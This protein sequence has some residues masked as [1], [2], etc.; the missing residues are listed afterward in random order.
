[1]GAIFSIRWASAAGTSEGDLSVRFVNTVN[2]L[3]TSVNWLQDGRA[4]A[5]TYDLTVL[6][7]VGSTITLQVD[8]NI[9][10]PYRSS[11]ITAVADG[12][13]VNELVIP[14]VGI[15]FSAAADVGWAAKVTVGQYLTSGGVVT[16]ALGFGVV[17]AGTE[18]SQVRFAVVNVGDM[19]SQETVI[20]A[21]PGLYWYGTNSEKIVKSIL[22][23]SSTARHKMA[24]PAIKTITFTNWGT[25]GNG[26]KKADVLVNGTTAIV[27]ALFD[28]QTVYEWGAGNGYNDSLDLLPGLAL[29][30]EDTTL[31]PTTVTV[32][33]EISDGYSWVQFAPDIAGAP[34]TF[35]Q[36]DL[37]LT[38]AGKPTGTIDVGGIAYAW[39]RMV[40]PMAAQ[41]GPMRKVFFR[42]RGL[43]V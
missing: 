18:S 11:S 35:A 29:V 37:T 43:S 36:Q 7:K 17:Q 33:L 3:I 34:G 26:K 9:K 16:P 4:I 38:Q 1:M 25:A 32:T 20:Y 5:D 8:C 42:V 10:N 30:L 23:H 41:A 39:A 31:D 19:P 27:G 24:S 12:A 28:G 13:T 14:G 22:P 6:S 2:A 15:V 21:L 40:V